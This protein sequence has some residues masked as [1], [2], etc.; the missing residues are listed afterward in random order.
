MSPSA[1]GGRR[2]HLRTPLR[3]R[4]EMVGPWTVF[5]DLPELLAIPDTEERDRRVSAFADEVRATIENEQ[6]EL[7]VF[8]PQDQALPAG[9][10]L[11]G[12]LLDLGA[13]S[14]TDY[15]PVSARAYGVDDRWVEG[16]KFYQRVD[17]RPR[18]RPG[19]GR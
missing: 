17:A 4:Q 14:L 19:S 12:L 18:E 7:L 16:W 13:L 8:S 10:T 11:H 3:L 5:L 9:S 6:P 2:R 1:P 15:R